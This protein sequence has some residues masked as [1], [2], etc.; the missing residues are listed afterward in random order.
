M[1]EKYK[2]NNIK[3]AL[4]TGIG[5]QDAAYM[6]MF[7]LEKG[8]KVFRIGRSINKDK[9]WRLEELGIKD[10]I[11]YLN[12]DITDALFIFDAFKSIQP[13]E[14]YNFAAVSFVGLSWKVPQSTISINVDGVVNILEAIKQN[15]SHTRLYQAGSSEM[16]G[17]SQTETQNELTKFDPCNPYGVSKL[18]AYNFT[19]IYRDVYGVYVSNAFCYNHESEL[20]GIE[21][22]TR[23]ITDGVARI[24]YG[25]SKELRL[26]NIESRR[27]WGF[28]GDYVKGMWAMLQQDKPDDY[29][30]AT[31]NTHS[32]REFLELAFKSVGIFDWEKYVVQDRN[33]YRPV[34]PFLLC[35]D[36]TKAEHNLNWK[37]ELNFEDLVAK[38]VSFDLKRI[39]KENG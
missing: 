25:F 13:D 31:G 23:K 36:S 6:A 9:L 3:K 15:S 26:G 27:D 30:L 20:R 19:K 33:F 18:A 28:A 24:A 29:V 38:M 4:I 1:E 2:N 39:K 11:E 16:F 7:L 10:K 34:E 22:V 37:A 17:K 21:Y 5:G 14:C 35:G 12:G 32:I 8:Y